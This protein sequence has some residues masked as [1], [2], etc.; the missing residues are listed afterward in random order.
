NVLENAI[1]MD[2]PADCI[3]EFD[4]A[5][6]YR[7]SADDGAPGFAHL[8]QTTGQDLLEY[9]RIPVFWKAHQCQRA[10]RLT[11]HRVDI[12]ERIYRRDLPEGER[13]VDDGREKICRLHE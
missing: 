7:M 12:A 3:A 1:R 10:D 6:T 4:L 8:G 5:I 9:V 2:G 13:V 11:A